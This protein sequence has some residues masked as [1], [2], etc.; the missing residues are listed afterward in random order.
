MYSLERLVDGVWIATSV[1]SLHW[2]DLIARAKLEKK[3]SPKQD[4]CVRKISEQIGK[5]K[6]IFQ[7]RIPTVYKADPLLFDYTPFID[8]VNEKLAFEN[9]LKISDLVQ[10][11][12]IP[13]KDARFLSAQLV[14]LGI[15]EKRIKIGREWILTPLSPSSVFENSHSFI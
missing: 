5:G 3:I 11:F 15:C 14:D 7:T 8:F 2:K 4:Y 12:G 6:I 13:Y 10:N 1:R 9:K